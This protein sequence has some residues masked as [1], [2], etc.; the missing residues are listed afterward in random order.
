[1]NTRKSLTDWN[2]LID[3]RITRDE[4][5]LL[6]FAE[7]KR[8]MES[9]GWYAQRCADAD[10][11]WCIFRETPTGDYRQTFGGHETQSEAVTCAVCNSLS[12]LWYKSA[13]EVDRALSLS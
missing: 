10:F 5:P 2:A 1:M 11:K 13:D 6:S 7:A 9:E 3:E 4:K 12:V 8:I